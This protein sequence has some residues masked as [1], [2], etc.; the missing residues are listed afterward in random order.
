MFKNKLTPLV[1]TFVDTI[2]RSRLY[3]AMLFKNL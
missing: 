1:F 2:M 3:S